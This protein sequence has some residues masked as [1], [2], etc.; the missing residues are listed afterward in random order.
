MKLEINL[1]KVLAFACKFQ[2]PGVF[3]HFTIYHG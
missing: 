2:P 3:L 1:T